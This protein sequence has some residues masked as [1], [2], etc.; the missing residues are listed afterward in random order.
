MLHLF[1]LLLPAPP[2]VPFFSL[3]V[4]PLRIPGYYTSTT[5]ITG[6][7]GKY[8]CFNRKAPFPSYCNPCCSHLLCSRNNLPKKGR[9]TFDLDRGSESREL[10]TLDRWR[11]KALPVT[12]G[13]SHCSV[14][15]VHAHRKGEYH[16]HQLSKKEFLT[17]SNSGGSS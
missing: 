17:S 13:R 12:H 2:T 9:K 11:S 16:R 15:L 3:P 7:T 6:C 4:L 14:T 10:W 8:C 5:L 1:S